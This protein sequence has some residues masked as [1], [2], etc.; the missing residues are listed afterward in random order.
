[1][2]LPLLATTTLAIITNWVQK[3]GQ[4][5]RHCEKVLRLFGEKGQKQGGG[6]GHAKNKSTANQNLNRILK[7]HC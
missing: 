3:L 5:L 1:M 4:I 6:G 7:K 2:S